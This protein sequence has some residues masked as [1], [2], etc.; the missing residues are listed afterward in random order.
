MRCFESASVAAGTRLRL[1]LSFHL[2]F[3]LLFSQNSVAKL[4]QIRVIGDEVV[5]VRSGTGFLR[6]H[7][8][9]I[10]PLNHPGDYAITDAL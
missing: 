9:A 7:S 10:I 6:A 1:H 8:H 4:A 3:V 5:R 2:M